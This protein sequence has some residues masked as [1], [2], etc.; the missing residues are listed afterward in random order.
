LNSVALS[1]GD[2]YM[3]TKLKKKKKY[4]LGKSKLCKVIQRLLHD[5]KQTVGY[6]AMLGMR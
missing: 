2:I 5:M 4:M 3:K 1:F 6:H